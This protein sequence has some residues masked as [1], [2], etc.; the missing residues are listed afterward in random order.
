MGLSSIDCVVV[1]GVVLAAIGLGLWGSR[2]AGRDADQYFL[3]GRNLSGWMLGLSM[4][5]TTFAADTPGLVTELV[6]TRGVAGNWAWWAFLLTGM[7]TVFLFA[8]L[9]RRT[10][11]RTDMELYELRY[12]G[13]AAAAL[14]VFR[15]LYLGVVFNVIIMAVVSVAAIK[16]GQVLLGVS[17]PMILV[18]GGMASLALT[19]FGGF[20]AVVLTDCLLFGVAMAGAFAAAYFALDH[21]EVGGLTNL[22]ASETIQPLL[23]V[24]PAWDWSSEQSRELIVATLL[25]PLAVQWWSAWYPGSEPGGGGYLAQRML[26]AKNEDHALGAVMLFNAFHYAL[27]PWPWILVALA[28]VL[29]YPDLDALRNAFPAVEQ[30][31]IGHDLAYPAMILAA[32][33]GWRG[34]IVASLAAAYVSTISTHLNWGASYVTHDFYRRVVAP[35]ASPDRLVL[36]GRLATVAMMLLASLL[37][38][39]LQSAKQGFD[40]VLSVGAG[41][42]L[43]YILRWYWWRINA[44]AEIV[45]MASSV[46]VAAYFPVGP[47]PRTRDLAIVVAQRRHNDFPMARRRDARTGGV[48]ADARVVLSPDAPGGARLAGGHPRHDRRAGAGR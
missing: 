33:T 35:D 2:S 7:L 44:S 4:V 8:R 43:I 46:L 13:P 41:T 18:A 25:V 19:A 45:A 20:R 38:L 10:G 32:P 9:W 29:V 15:A 1:V 17:P 3:S 28:S 12:S 22:L 47:R 37:A 5:A 11:V 26:A 39:R 34:L 42:G 21:P 24:F 27:R 31:K 6:R 16:I 36:V 14:R 23:P 48:S 40:L 30:S